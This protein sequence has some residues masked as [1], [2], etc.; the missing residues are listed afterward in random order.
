[1]LEGGTTRASRFEARLHRLAEHPTFGWPVAMGLRHREKVLYLIVG[2]WNTLFGYL[3]WVVLQLLFYPGLS[4][5]VT[6]AISWP[7]AI[8]NAY[9]GYRYIVFHSKGPWW[10]ELPRFSLVYFVVLFLDLVILPLL[11]RVLPFNVYV[12]QAGFIFVVVA[13]S[14]LGHKY[15]SFG[16][17]SSTASP[18]TMQAAASAE[19]PDADAGSSSAPAARETS[20]PSERALDAAYYLAA[21]LVPFGV[22]AWML[23]LWSFT[24][25]APV[26]YS[27][28][29]LYYMAQIKGWLEHGPLYVNPSLGAPGVSQLYDFPSADALN[30]LLI[31]FFG[32]FG[33]GP[34]AAMNLFYLAGY[35]LIG[36]ATAFVLRRLGLSRVVALAATVLYLFVPY[37]W[38]RGEGHLY[39]GMFWIVPLQ[40]LVLWWIA[41]P[42]PPLFKPGSGYS[43]AP[44]SGRTLAAVAISLAAGACGIYYLFFGCCFLALVGARAAIRRRTWR[45]AVAAAVLIVLSGGVLVAQ[46]VPTIVYQH[47]HGDNPVAAARTPVRGRVVRTPRHADAAA[48][49]RPPD[50]GARGKTSQLPHLQP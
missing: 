33:A 5:L 23:D 42:E 25:S 32:L 49:R 8:L 36:V 26:A 3:L 7:F 20:R 29:A 35:P 10:K 6:L 17:A 34:G 13:L 27:I 2:G 9:I 45:P 12:C 47:R 46:M 19:A 40:V 31:R 44:R 48:H 43:L 30:V 21:A 24:V 15:F 41:S 18:A 14:Y 16:G 37:H 22:I 1:M 28:D 4:Y 50:P 38:M 39:L 11:L